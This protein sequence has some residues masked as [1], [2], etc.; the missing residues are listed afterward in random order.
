MITF[1]DMERD[2]WIVQVCQEL[3]VGVQKVFHKGLSSSW[4]SSVLSVVEKFRSTNYAE[5]GWTG[6]LISVCL[7]EVMFVKSLAVFKM[8]FPSLTIHFSP[9]YFDVYFK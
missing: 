9:V 1:G 3:S 7:D 6:P 2:V 5:N 4:R 8:K